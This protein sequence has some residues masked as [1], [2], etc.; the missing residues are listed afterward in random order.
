MA[1]TK[2]IRNKILSITNTKKITKTMEMVAISKIKKI[3][4]RLLVSQPYLFHIKTLISHFFNRK[5]KYSH[6]LLKKEREIKN[7]GILVVTSNRGLCGNLNHNVY[8][9]I[10]NIMKTNHKDVVYHLYI[11]GLKGISFFKQKRNI[12]IKKMINTDDNIKYQQLI[13]FIKFIIQ[14]YEEN[15]IDKLLIVSNHCQ[16]QI[17]Q[18]S[19]IIQLLPLKEEIFFDQKY[20]KYSRWDYIYESKEKIILDTVFQSYMIFQVFQ[21]ILE[22]ILSEHSARMITMKTASDN[23]ENIIKELGLLYNKTRQFSITQELTEI[24]SGSPVFC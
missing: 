7:I 16:N 17:L 22:N 9:K 20:T 8:K 12:Y 11:F 24:I 6:I 13:P 23:S 3:K 4:S 1:N 2:V 14:E 19:H 18:N 10:F 5:K 15:R 21:L